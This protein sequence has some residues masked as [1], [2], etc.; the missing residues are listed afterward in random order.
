[1]TAIANSLGDKA[2]RVHT[3]PTETAVITDIQTLRGVSTWGQFNNFQ[4]KGKRAKDWLETD[5]NEPLSP[6]ILMRVFNPNKKLEKERINE[7]LIDWFH[8]PK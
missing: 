8:T 3:L 7:K 1:M 2:T 6:E 4:Y 5:W